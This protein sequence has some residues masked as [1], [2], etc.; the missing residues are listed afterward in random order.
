MSHLSTSELAELLC[1]FDGG[2]VAFDFETWGTDASAPD[3]YVR[4][5]GLANSSLCCAVDLDNS[6][7]VVQVCQWLSRQGQLVAHNYVFDGAWIYKY[8]EELPLAWADTYG[9]FRQLATEGWSHPL[10]QTWGLKTAMTD[11][12]GW[13]EQNDQELTDWLK[14]NGFRKFEMAKAPWDILGKYNA[15]DAGATWQL[16]EYF[17][18]VLRQYDWGDLLWNYHQQEHLGEVNLL[19]QQQ[20]SGMQLDLEKLKD[21]DRRLIFEIMEKSNEFLAIPEV[22]K[23]ITRYNDLNSEKIQEFAPKKFKKNGD[24]S[25]VWEKW[26]EKRR[27]AVAAGIWKFAQKKP[28]SFNLNSGPDLV[29]LF[30]G[31]LGYEIKE[32]TDSGAP[33]VGKKVLPH[34]GEGGVVLNAYRLLRDEHKFVRAALYLQRDGVF[35]PK[36]KSVATVTGRLGGGSEEVDGKKYR[37]NIQQLPKRRGFLEC[38]VARPGHKLVYTDFSALEMKVSAIASQDK[39]LYKLYGP[40]ANPNHDVYLFNGAQIPQYSAEIRE[41]YDLDNPTKEGKKAAK[42][43][44]SKIRGEIF[45]PWVLGCQYG[46]GA[47]TLFENLTLAGVKGITFEYCQELIKV[48]RNTYPGLGRLQRRLK[49]RWN[50]NKG[51]FTNLRGRPICVDVD[52]LKDIVN[53]NIQSSG[54][55]YLMLYLQFLH[56]RIKGKATPWLVDEH[57]A[58]IWEVEDKNVDYVK[59]MFELA[60][61]DLN[62]VLGFDI[63]FSGDTK[64]ASNLAELK[65]ED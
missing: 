32:R 38:F 43:K 30:F 40:G 45:K 21:Y 59:M 37:L 47:P 56:R 54:H 5:V 20:F 6:E 44:F 15:L 36:V 7:Q 31:E 9:L 50:T 3:S 42:E 24:I 2:P 34:L 57:D 4:S 14:S 11:V 26:D 52:K 63:K 28:Q 22:S 8:T 23:V 58:T 19:I 17:Q 29:K 35:H 13:E 16:F 10:P 41:L 46:L 55:D 53:R 25:K 49:A 62:E 12:L 60:F 1:K 27:V 18:S 33:S 48:F 61:D 39:N 65:V 51:W 64:V